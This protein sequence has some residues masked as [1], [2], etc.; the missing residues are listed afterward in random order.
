M[1][2]LFDAFN[3]LKISNHRTFEAAEKAA[4]AHGKAVRKNNGKNS[5][6]PTVIL[7]ICPSLR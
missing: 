4:I 7:R 5:Y 6:I 2:Q 1:Y 3:C